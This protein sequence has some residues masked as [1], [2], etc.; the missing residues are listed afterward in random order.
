MLEGSVDI[1]SVAGQLAI[2]TVDIEILGN[3]AI[4]DVGTLRWDG[5]EDRFIHTKVLGQDVFRCVGDPISDV[6]CDSV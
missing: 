1:G 4:E 5:V 3:R 2:G 6:E